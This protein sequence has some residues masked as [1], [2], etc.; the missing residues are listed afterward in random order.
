M[1]LIN[2]P[3]VLKVASLTLGQSFAC[4]SANKFILKYVANIDCYITATNIKSVTRVHVLWD[5]LYS[6]FMFTT[7]TS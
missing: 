5:I 3:I 7:M 1:Y 6:N 4:P 2:L